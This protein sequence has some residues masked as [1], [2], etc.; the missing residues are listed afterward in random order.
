MLS[1]LEMALIMFQIVKSADPD[2][3]CKIFLVRAYP[4]TQDFSGPPII[5]RNHYLGIPASS[6]SL[7]PIFDWMNYLIKFFLFFF[8]E[9]S[10]EGKFFM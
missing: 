9:I 2:G 5:Y 8:K 4:I 6:A 7:D 10:I 3:Y 1:A